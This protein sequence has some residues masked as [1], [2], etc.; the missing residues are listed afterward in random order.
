MIKRF[1]LALALALCCAARASALSTCTLGGTVYN[2]DRSFAVN[3][4]ATIK[5][6]TTQHVTGGIIRPSSTTVL[7]NSSGVMPTVNV[8]QGIIV[9]VQVGYGT[10][11]TITIRNSTSATLSSLLSAVR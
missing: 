6:P 11:E 7:T 1:V 2:L 5:S 3:A 9:T 4:R 8:S 10:P